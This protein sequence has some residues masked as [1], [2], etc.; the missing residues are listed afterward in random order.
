MTSV[1]LPLPH[2]GTE[3]Y[4]LAGPREWTKPSAPFTSRTAYAAA[5]V[6]PRTLAENVPGAPAD[7]DWDRTLA[8]R[9]EL[10]SYGLGVAEAMDTAQRG[11]G[12]D[13]TAAAEL[14]RRSAAEAATVGGSIACG[15][16]T[17]Q[18]ALDAVP[19]GRQG[20]ATVIDAYREQM[21]VVADTGATTIVMASRALAR[22]ARDAD[23]YAEV[24]ATLLDEAESPV[25]LHWL[26]DMFDP[27]LAGYWG[28]SSV[29]EATETFLDVIRARPGKVDGVKVSLLDAEHEVGLRR[30]LPEGVR[31]YTGDDFNY[32]ELIVG[33]GSG[34][35]EFSHAL[36]GIFAAIYPAA[37]AALQALDRG[38]PAEAR[39]LL[40]ST[41]ALGRKI[42]EA[43]T[44]YYKTGIAFLSWLGG[45][46]PGFSM[47]GGLHAGR[48]V[49]HL[50]EVF[51]LADAAGLLTSPD[52][53]AARMRAFLTVQ[54]VDQ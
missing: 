43:P 26:G 14:I 35:G 19:E 4:P 8:Y 30:A 46:Q 45:H 17:D 13:W 18:L 41:Q 32:P 3:L 22:V 29:A 10:W 52:L 25:I 1:R 21:K 37:S 44:Y 39:A 20:L 7:I 34:E 23:D 27:A 36:L 6:V 24:Y 38:D 53:A 12:V 49:P 33:E 15:A 48:S 51:R 50:A 5:H 31:L 16:G 47:A 11:M 40:E 54:G 28:S 42:F 2:G 9:H